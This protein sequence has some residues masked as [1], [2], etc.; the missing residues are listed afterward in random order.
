MRTLPLRTRLT[1]V[2]SGLL[3]LALAI[4]GTAVMTLLR[5]RLTL[6]MDAALD[7]RLQGVENFLIRET[8]AATEYKIPQEL[9]EYASTQ[10]E[11]H[12]IEVVDGQ[13]HVVLKSDPVP[14]PARSR[15]KSFSIYGKTYRTRAA[16]S[17]EPIE[18]SIHEIGLLLLGSSPV[19]LALIG[20][21]G[22][23]I[24][25]RSLRPVDEMTQAARTIGANSLSGRLPVPHA[26][27]EISRLA[28]AWNEMLER[29]EESFVR[30]QRFT[31]DA[32]HELRTPLAALR[33]TADLSLRR[34]RDPQEYRDALAQVGVIAE[35]MNQLA[36]GL[37]S[38][39]RGDQALA[40]QR[41]ERVDFAALVRGAAAE[42]QP[43]FDDKDVHLHVTL[44]PKP[45]HI[46]ADPD[47]LR[48][49]LA[50]LLDNA[51]KYSYAGG[52]V[53]MSVE[54]GVEGPTLEVSDTGRGIPPESLTRIFD[55]FYRVDTSRDR[56]TGGY[57]L[58]LSIAQQIARAHQGQIVAESVVGQGS[59]FR[60]KLPASSHSNSGPMNS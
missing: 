15:E 14:L 49:V 21:T 41:F 39:A 6:R 16:A 10:P 17:A 34:E 30:M 22:Y 58:G 45:I 29:L 40:R 47:G 33:T 32:A 11:G 44:P 51:L 26:R 53:T 19:L 20:L 23:W 9:E 43:L 60:L 42:M 56:K 28:E 1:L 4:S 59:S 12:Y 13:G 52:K 18:D 3:F 35:R 46:E 38:I 48:R 25:S 31:E 5:Y 50:I 24:S 57:G 7:H 54:N 8:T 55:R 37:L 36:E 2:Y 27:D